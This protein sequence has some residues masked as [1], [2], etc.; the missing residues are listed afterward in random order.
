MTMCF[1]EFGRRVFENTNGTDHGTA[2]PMFC[3]GS[4]VN[5]GLA[6]DWPGI[7]LEQRARGGDDIRAATDPRQVYSQVM[8]EWLGGDPAAVMPGRS[9]PPSPTVTRSSGRA[10]A[11]ARSSSSSTR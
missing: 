11:T 5:G 1:T 8:T 2:G 7:A 3:V 10:S 9:G 4:R 6:G